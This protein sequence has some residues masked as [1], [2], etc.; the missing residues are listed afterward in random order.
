MIDKHE[1]IIYNGLE[2]CYPPTDKYAT[3]FVG[4]KVEKSGKGNYTDLQKTKRNRS[5]T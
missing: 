3:N 4:R 5:R 2:K 1:D